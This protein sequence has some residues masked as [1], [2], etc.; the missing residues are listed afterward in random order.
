[1]R[2]TAKSRPSEA[3]KQIRHRIAGDDKMR[4]TEECRPSEV[5]QKNM[6]SICGDIISKEEALTLIRLQLNRTL[7]YMLTKALRNSYENVFSAKKSFNTLI[8]KVKY[9][10]IEYV[11]RYC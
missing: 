4:K 9:N 8:N 2:K 11:F 7:P 5:S 10:R 1:M 3:P 6:Q